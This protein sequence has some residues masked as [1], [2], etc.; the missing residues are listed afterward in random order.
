MEQKNSNAQDVTG[1][2]SNLFHYSRD[3]KADLVITKGI[4]YLPGN[5][6]V[7]KKYAVF[8]KPL[9]PR[10]NLKKLWNLFWNDNRYVS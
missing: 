3:Q 1:I 6:V 10:L 2:L 4:F 8:I 7:K 9:H 5:S